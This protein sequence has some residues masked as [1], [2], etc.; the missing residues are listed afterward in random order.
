MAS[1]PLLYGMD[2]LQTAFIMFLVGIV[3]LAIY[4]ILKKKT[5]RERPCSASDEIVL[6]TQPLDHY[7][8]PSGH[9]LHAVAFSI[10]LV[11]VYPF[12]SW[13]LIPFTLLVAMSRVVLGLHYPTDVAAGATIGTITASIAINLV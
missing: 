12:M 10:I 13:V 5:S 3:N 4:K 6:G 2:G 9:T 1:L 11:S 7:S 8:F